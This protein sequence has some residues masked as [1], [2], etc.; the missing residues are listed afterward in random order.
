MDSIDQD[1]VLVSH[2]TNGVTTI[3]FNRPKQRNAMNRAARVGIIRALDACRGTSRVVVLKGSGPSF[4]AGVDIK[5]GPVSTGDAELDRRSEWGEVQEELR[6][7]PAIVIAAVGGFALG[8]GLTLVNTA[9]LAIAADEASFGLP[10][11]GF[12]MYPAFAG[13]STQLR[14]NQKRAAWLVLTSDRI[15]GKTAEQWGLVN[16]SVPLDQLDAEADALA[17]R[18]AAFSDVGLEVSKELLWKVPSEASEW[19]AAI[20]LGAATTDRIRARKADAD[21][22]RAAF[23][24]GQRNPGQGT[25]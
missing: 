13:P 11:I 4:C 12:G 25:A 23:A 6:R 7:H 17:E 24:Q 16:K 18:I 20:A 10:E 3:T 5:E 15:D 22:G 8:G 2:G 21:A 9:D 19:S 1:A 14:I